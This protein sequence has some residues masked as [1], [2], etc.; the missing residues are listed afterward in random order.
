GKDF[1]SSFLERFENARSN[2][3]ANRDGRT[4]YSRFVKP[5]ML[6]WPKTVAHYAISSVF[7]EYE[8]QIRVYS[9]SFE[10]EDR[11]FFTSGKTR[12][13][14]GRTKVLSEITQESD[15]L[16]YAILYLG[17]HNLTG[18]VKKFD[19]QE[20]YDQMVTEVKAAYDT[21]DFPEIIRAIDRH[22]GQPAYTLKSLFKDE[23]RRILDEILESTREDL[24]HRFRLIAE[25]YTPLMKFLETVN[26]PLP[27]ALESSMDFVLHSDICRK[28]QAEP[29]DLEQLG[30]LLEEARH[31]DGQV[32]DP[33][34]SFAV[35]NRM[36]Q[37][38]QQLAQKPEDLERMQV[39][40][41]LAEL[42][43]P[44]PL[45][46]NLWKV[47]DDYWEML[48]TVAP[49]FQQRAEAGDPAASQWLDHFASLG[50]RLGFVVQHLRRAAPT[51]MA[52]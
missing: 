28:L 29:L 19:S 35:K 21:A 39:L 20:A 52:A 36:E 49:Q 34:I 47:Q 32:L 43:V 8:K 2:I 46:L 13:A 51:K 4:I 48:G 31:R 30:A 17:E 41:G 40:Q 11:H 25:R 18:G 26:A 22:F 24:D 5:A 16:S 23:Q 44:L 33:D 14:M 9:F 3:A 12:L 27:A 42:V 15:V 45:G 7:S 50:E 10:N 1:E 6:D 37:L 38:M